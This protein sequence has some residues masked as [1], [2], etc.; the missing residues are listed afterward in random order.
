MVVGKAV[1]GAGSEMPPASLSGKKMS[2]SLCKRS[3]PEGVDE[4]GESRR[5]RNVKTRRE[6]LDGYLE[7]IGG[8]R[9]RLHCHWRRVCMR[10]KR[11]DRA[12]SVLTR[13]SM[14]WVA[15]RQLVQPA[16]V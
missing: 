10:R 13:C 14:V 12:G 4:E 7:D 16:G 11:L 3:M 6:E 9:K 2:V 1:A 5:R 15:G 8:D